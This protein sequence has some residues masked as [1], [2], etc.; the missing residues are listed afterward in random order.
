MLNVTE[1]VNEERRT[2][3]SNNRAAFIS[4]KGSEA[5]PT[6]GPN[7]R[8]VPTTGESRPNKSGLIESLLSETALNTREINPD[9]PWRG[10]RSLIGSRVS[11]LKCH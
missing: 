11:P 10:T 8:L 6:R 3:I 5:F 4:A 1:P 9:D 2:T 7:D